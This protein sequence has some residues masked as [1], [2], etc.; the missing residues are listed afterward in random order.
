[1]HCDFL[2]SDGLQETHMDAFKPFNSKLV[3]LTMRGGFFTKF[4]ALAHGV[5]PLFD[6]SLFCAYY[7]KIIIEKMRS[8]FVN[9][10]HIEIVGIGFIKN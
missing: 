6:A 3:T 9:A 1:M 7:N 4:A 8:H 2:G 10:N 5:A